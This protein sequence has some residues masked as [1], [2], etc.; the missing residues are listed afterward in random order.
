MGSVNWVEVALLFA[1]GITVAFSVGFC[2]GHYGAHKTTK[3]DL[4][5]KE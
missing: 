2:A 3:K 5:I 1:L 4:L